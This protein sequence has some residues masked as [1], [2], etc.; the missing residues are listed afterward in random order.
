MCDI[1][2]NCTDTDGSYL[3]ACTAGFSGSGLSCTGMSIKK[4]NR[5]LRT[6]GDMMFVVS[7]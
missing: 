4:H 5:I 2:A 3:C 7:I 6:F 1:N